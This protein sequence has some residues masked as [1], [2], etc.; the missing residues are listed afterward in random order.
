MENKH[1]GIPAKA[2]DGYQAFPIIIIKRP[3]AF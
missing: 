1:L 2:E 3:V